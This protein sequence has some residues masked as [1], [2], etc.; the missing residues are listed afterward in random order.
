MHAAPS[1][2]PRPLFLLPPGQMARHSLLGMLR[3]SQRLGLNPGWI[4]V[5]TLRDRARRADGSRSAISL[6]IAEQRYRVEAGGFTHAV[7]FGP[8]GV[9]DF[10]LPT[11]STP[12]SLWTHLG[13]NVAMWWADHPSWLS[14][15]SALFEPA[16]TMCAGSV[17]GHI[18]KS[19]PTADEAR[20]ILGWSRVDSMPVAEDYEV[21][22]P[23]KSGEPRHDVVVVAHDVQ[24]VAMPLKRFLAAD[25]PD[26][27]TME[28]AMI[29]QAMSQFSK[30][31][32]EDKPAIRV[33]LERFASELLEARAC[34]P[35]RTVHQLATQLGADHGAALIYLTRKGRRWYKTQQILRQA[36]TWR[37]SF[38]LAWLAQRVEL[39]VYGCDAKAIGVP[40]AM[41]ALSSVAHQDLSRVYGL[42]KCAI[43]I[44]P[45]CDEASVTHEVFQ[46]AG[47]GVPCIHHATA[48][49]GELF[50]I[51]RE[52]MTFSRGPELLHA[53]DHLCAHESL[54]EE[55]GQR[56][57]SRTRAQHAWEHRVPRLLGTANQ[58][59]LKAA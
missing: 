19:K 29:P 33:A 32:R 46:I 7:S 23:M 53:V 15:E 35:L 22:R 5:Q 55:F 59:T 9:I 38:W 36:T 34:E 49:L 10:T 42:G 43:S 8:S 54:R 40:Q 16:R 17:Y 56:A 11:G 45:A 20:E 30:F 2:T 25:D 13:L 4:E 50:D 24:P 14:A 39:G 6:L 51:G 26:P 28:R 3:A 48:G 47:S 58:A 44:N 18:V 31:I 21:V 27:A 12:E 41:E 37:R 52:V 57:L 1:D